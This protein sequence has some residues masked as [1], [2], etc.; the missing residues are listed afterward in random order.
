MVFVIQFALLGFLVHYMIGSPTFK[1]V[2]PDSFIVL[3]T[4]F[5]ATVMMH[6][7]VESKVRD[8]LHMMKYVANHPEA[9]TLPA[10]A[11]SV[12]LM[13]TIGGITSEIMCVVFL[14]SLN[15]VIEVI[16]RFMAFGSIANVDMFYS[17]MLPD[18]QAFRIKLPSGTFK[19][20]NMNRT[21]DRRDHSCCIRVSRIVY[22]LIRI[23]YCSYIF[24]FMPF[25]T[26]WLPYPLWV[27]H[28]CETI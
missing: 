20:V 3:V 7:T 23:I 2:M 10:F 24:Y 19:V 9:F 26:I 11:F 13:K 21:L 18:V 28:L 1:I 8:G 4:R 6:L 15:N 22:K 16:I 17:E 5:V 14:T 12:G 27:P 25:T